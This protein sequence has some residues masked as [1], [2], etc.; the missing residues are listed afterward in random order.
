M[1]H[2]H[3]PSYHPRP[4]RK[5]HMC[6]QQPIPPD[7]NRASTHTR[8]TAIWSRQGHGEGAQNSGASLHAEKKVIESSP[9]TPRL[10]A[11]CIERSIAMFA[12]YHSHP[13]T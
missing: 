6:Q 3:K 10:S 12:Y 13:Y 8:M 4:L 2:I 7:E 1:R 9:S 5:H 11:A